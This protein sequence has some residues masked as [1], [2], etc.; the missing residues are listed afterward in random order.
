MKKFQSRFE[1]LRRIRVQA[2]KLARVEAARRN[3][4]RDQAV[5]LQT[6]CEQSLQNALRTAS[7]QLQKSTTGVFIAA[8]SSE[9]A[10]HEQ[11]LANAEAAVQVATERVRE[12]MELFTNARRELRTV[13]EMIHREQVEHRQHEL[14]LEEQKQQEQASQ[15]WHSRRQDSERNLS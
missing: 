8:M 4:E 6:A 7:Q 2:E 12:A 14:L 15:Q 11:N 9:V 13:E 10:I 1:Q 3:S 5:A